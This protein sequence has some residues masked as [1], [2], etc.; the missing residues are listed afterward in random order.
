MAGIDES[1]EVG[2]IG[3]GVIPVEVLIGGR[4]SRKWMI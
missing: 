1:E 2:E 4:L 3:G